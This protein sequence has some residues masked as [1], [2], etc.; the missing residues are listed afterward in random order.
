MN[1]EQINQ[2]I[3]QRIAKQYMNGFV[4]VMIDL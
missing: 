3:F 2:L 4:L 1:T